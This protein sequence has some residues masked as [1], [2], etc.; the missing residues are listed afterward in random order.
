MKIK[1]LNEEL[2]KPNPDDVIV[3]KKIHDIIETHNIAIHMAEKLDEMTRLMSFISF[4][5]NTFNVCFLIF[6]FGIVN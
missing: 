5:T 2:Q 3:K 6:V 4:F 1:H